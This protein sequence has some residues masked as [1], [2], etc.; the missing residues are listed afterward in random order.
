MS[1]SVAFQPDLSAYMT[2]A[3]A[4]TAI[5]AMNTEI[6]KAK[7]EVAALPNITL[8]GS[9]LLSALAG[10]KKHVVACVGALPGDRFGQLVPVASM[11]AGY[12]LGDIACLVADQVEVTVYLPSVTLLTN[13]SISVRV[14]ALRP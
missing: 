14:T 3:E 8:S 11:P 9:I 6:A 5:A 2:V 10:P 7:S 1:D 4:N 13:Y 12:M